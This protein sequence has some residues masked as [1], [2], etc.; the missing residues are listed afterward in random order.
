MNVYSKQSTAATSNLLLYTSCLNTYVDSMQKS[1]D[2]K[3]INEDEPYFDQ[4][5]LQNIHELAKEQSL[6]KVWNENK[7]T[8]SY[9]I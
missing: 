8:E 2:E 6:L 9:K 5:D 1:I 4:F 3:T 7:C